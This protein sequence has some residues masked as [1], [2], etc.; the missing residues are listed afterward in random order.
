MPHPPELSFVPVLCACKYAGMIWRVAT[1]C[2]GCILMRQFM[3]SR[4]LAWAAICAGILAGSALAAAGPVAAQQ[5]E[6]A[7]GKKHA[8]DATRSLFDAVQA[9]DL[10]AVQASIAAGADISARDQW[11]LTPID[12]AID[13]SYFDVAHFLLS[14]RNFQQGAGSSRGATAAPQSAFG[15][16]AAPSAANAPQERRT[17]TEPSRP[18]PVMSQDPA[19]PAEVKRPRPANRW[20]A[21]Q[22][23]PFDPARPAPGA[24]LPADRADSAERGFRGT[25]HT[26]SAERPQ[27]Q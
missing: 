20:P 6:P 21:D 25:G 5:T 4:G 3:R 13:K 7:A 23:N 9:N 11:G 19:H 10:A 8:G 12:L 15:P 2:D 16:R 22:P 24:V 14:M 26:A 1:T 18:A 27:L 17:R